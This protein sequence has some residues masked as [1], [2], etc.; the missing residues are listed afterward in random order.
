MQR[1]TDIVE[2][3]RLQ[4]Y[5]QYIEEF[6]ADFDI[7]RL[8][9]VRLRF[10]VLKSIAFNTYIEVAVEFFSE[11]KDT[12]AVE[13]ARS[14]FINIVEPVYSEACEYNGH[15]LLNLNNEKVYIVEQFVC[16]WRLVIRFT[17]FL[18]YLKTL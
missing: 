3:R 9:N 14:L 17:D 7:K 2:Q 13:M 16:D 5:K 12:E 18:N 6:L 15:Y 4:V 8:A 10:E 1:L 11:Q